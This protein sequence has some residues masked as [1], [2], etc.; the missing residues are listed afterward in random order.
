MPVD[1]VAEAR[2][3]V[4]EIVN[5]AWAASAEPAGYPAAYGA[6]PPPLF[7]QDVPDD[8]PNGTPYALAS[9]QHRGGGPV[10]IGDAGLRRFRAEG[11]ITVTVWAPH[12]DG[13]TTSDHLVTIAQDALEARHT[14]D[15]VYFR[16]VRVVDD[17]RDGAN[18]KVRVVADIDYDRVK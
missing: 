8:V 12:G 4:M 10:A 14:P 3:F 2:D 11:T 1:N 13:L 15:K 9:I 5:T 7:F 17:G 16:H 18:S 6:W